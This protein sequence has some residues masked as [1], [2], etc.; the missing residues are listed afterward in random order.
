LIEQTH[1]S[2]PFVF[3]HE[4]QI[5][6]LPENE[7]GGKLTLYRAIDFPLHWEPCRIL[8]EDVR[9]VDTT[10]HPTADGFIG[11]AESMEEPISDY[12]LRFDHR[13][14]LTECTPIEE[15]GS[16]C[17]RC[18]GPMFMHEGH[19]VRVTQ[20]CVHDYG[21]ALYFRMCD[22]VTLSEEYAV[23]ITPQQL[24]LNQRIFLQGMHTYSSSGDFEVI[25]IK[26]RRLVPVNLFYR[27]FGKVKMLI[28]SITRKV[29][30]L[31]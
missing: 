2:Y 29:E 3:C 5:Y 23:R 4:D 22:P 16:N 31:P 26:T 19:L 9:W 10:L 24:C 17:H 15:S 13:L 14:K 12:R 11:F 27:T 21:Q 20:D 1:L 28:K 18:G 25:D 8:A 6:M 7:A 30:S